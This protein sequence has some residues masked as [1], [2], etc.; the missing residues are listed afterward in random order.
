M[1]F[2]SLRPACLLVLPLV[3]SA[4]VEGLPADPK[5]PRM[6]Q[7][8]TCF[9]YVTAEPGGLFALVSGK[10]DGTLTP[11]GQ[12]SKPMSAEAVD[13]AFAKEVQVLGIMP[14][15]LAVYARDR[16]A[17]QPAA[18]MTAPAPTAPAPTAPKA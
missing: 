17:A 9:T 14:E 12:K 8:G 6:S 4:C 18:R 16:S 1:P 15:C 5:A 10:G 13:A 2:A 11:L 7:K 3:L